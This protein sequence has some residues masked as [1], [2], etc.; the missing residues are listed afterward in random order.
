MRT[1]AKFNQ[2]KI[3]YNFYAGKYLTRERESETEIRNPLSKHLDNKGYLN[4]SKPFTFSIKECIYIS[5]A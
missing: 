2:N 3:L 5:V 4:F 1:G